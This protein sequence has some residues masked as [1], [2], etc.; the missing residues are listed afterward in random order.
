M[1]VSQQG[2]QFVVSPRQISLKGA[3]PSKY[4]SRPEN[5]EHVQM[6]PVAVFVSWFYQHLWNRVLFFLFASNLSTSR[7]GLFC[8]FMAVGSGKSMSYDIVYTFAT[9]HRLGQSGSTWVH[10]FVTFKDS[11]CKK[12]DNKLNKKEKTNCKSVFFFKSI[13]ADSASVVLLFFGFLLTRHNCQPL[14]VTGVLLCF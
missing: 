6:F 11:F 13:P 1:K 4:A 8:F 9:N 7:F 10:V 3:P 14:C 2:P 12:L 5:A